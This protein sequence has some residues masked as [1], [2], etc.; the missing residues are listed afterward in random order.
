MPVEL[1]RGGHQDE[2][3]ERV[4]LY[5]EDLPNV[6]RLEISHDSRGK[7][8]AWAYIPSKDTI[9]V[10][11]FGS[12][13]L[14]L[15]DTLKHVIDV[16]KGEKVITGILYDDGYAD[17]FQHVESDTGARILDALSNYFSIY[18]GQSSYQNSGGTWGL[19]GRD[20][21]DFDDDDDSIKEPQTEG[22]WKQYLHDY[23]MGSDD[24]DSTEDPTL[25]PKGED[26]RD[27]GAK[28]WR[29][30]KERS[31]PEYGGWS[32]PRE[33][34]PH[35]RWSYGNQEIVPQAPHN[36]L[37]MWPVKGGYP[38]HYSQTGHEGLG[39]CAQGRVY[40]HANDRYEILTWPNRPRYIKDMQ[41]RM[42]LQ[43][44]AQE[45]AKQWLMNNLDIPEDKIFF[46][47]GQYM[48][49]VSNW[50]SPSYPTWSSGY[51]RGVSYNDNDASATWSDD[52]TEVVTPG[53]KWQQSRPEGIDDIVDTHWGPG[54]KI[55]RLDPEPNQLALPSG[56]A[57]DRGRYLDRINDSIQNK[58]EKPDELTHV[59]WY[60]MTPEERYEYKIKQFED[61]QRNR[62]ET[63]VTY[64]PD[65]DVIP[66][67]SY[68]A[69]TKRWIPRDKPSTYSPG[70]TI[71]QH[72]GNI[73]SISPED[74]EQAKA[75]Y[76]D[77]WWHK[78]LDPKGSSTMV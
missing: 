4:E 14:D 9:Y 3:G 37:F 12:D 68:D 38:D 70:M 30:W 28:E 54:K 51:H 22:D 1:D 2:E 71:T 53:H 32:N 24:R 39:Y 48:D 61:S 25:N 6:V 45:A 36:G 73:V 43:N 35:Y 31:T 13:S 41:I 17:Y 27:W 52:D 16:K 34:K 77:S 7:E 42:L 44:E 10:G 76:G 75:E 5:D 29:N 58:R 20:D 8:A 69:Q 64:D 11:P 47:I 57:A 19:P 46:T 65:G 56:P 66:A 23:G 15:V 18:F 49:M 33:D 72:D 40:P 26:T 74:Y 21:E 63:G 60:M 67:G 62:N 59:E 50:N 55:D 78:W